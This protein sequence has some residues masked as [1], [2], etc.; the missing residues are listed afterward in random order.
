M[1]NQAIDSKIKM[2]YEKDGLIS[3]LFHSKK[4]RYRKKEIAS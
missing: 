1:Q 4:L 2:Y 3:D